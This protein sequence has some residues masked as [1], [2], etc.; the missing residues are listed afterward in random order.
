MAERASPDP[1]P[2]ELCRVQPQLSEG[3]SIEVLAVVAAGN[4]AV[5]EVRVPHPTVGPYY[6]LSFVEVE[7][8]RLAT[9][10][11]VKAFNDLFKM[12]RHGRAPQRT[13]RSICSQ[14]N[15]SGERGDEMARPR[16]TT[17][18]SRPTATSA[19]EFKCPE[20]GK[21]FTRAASL[22]AHR[23]RAHGITGTSKRRTTDTASTPAASTT[24]ARRRR[25]STRRRTT[26][27][28]ATTAS[29]TR[30]QDGKSTVNRNQLLQ[31]LFPNG[32]PPR[33][34]VIRRIGNWLDEA[35]QLAKL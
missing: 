29:R 22:G 13:G 17:S 10:T 27:T 34:D 18:A 5:S 15:N 26:S 24:R 35:E 23:N 31:A 12:A 7:D 11:E 28:A 4:I 21:T 8:G 9:T 14:A 30:Q 3:W 32:V 25:G 33:E 20:C 2:D 16:R 19:G 1:R 6:A